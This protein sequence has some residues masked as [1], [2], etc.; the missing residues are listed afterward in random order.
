MPKTR[1]MQNNISSQLSTRLNLNQRRLLWHHHRNR[2]SSYLTM[3]GQSLSMIT[4]R[5]S[6]HSDISFRL[7]QLLAKI[8]STTFFETTGNLHEIFFK[9]NVHTQLLGQSRF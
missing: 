2:S 1:S 5:S 7:R 3:S 8:P 9:V 4:G 6:H